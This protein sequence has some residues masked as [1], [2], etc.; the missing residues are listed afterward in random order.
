MQSFRVFHS[1][2][3]AQSTL[4]R[5]ADHKLRQSEGI[6]ASQNAVLFILMK[7]NGI[8]MGS[9][10]KALKMSKSSLSTVI[11]KMVDQGLIRRD[12]KQED[13]RV[14]LIFIETPGIDIIKRTA[15]AIHQVNAR[16]LAPFNDAER[17]IIARFLTHI[18]SNA[19]DI[20]KDA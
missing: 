20:V 4:F 12:K 14:I 6:T 15:A 10:A 3:K 18:E 16:L 8:P 9:I 17:D 5:A 13:G 1:L 2:Q 7:G 19:V 11:D